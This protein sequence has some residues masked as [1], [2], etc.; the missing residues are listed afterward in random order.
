MCKEKEV[1]DLNKFIWVWEEFLCKKEKELSE[2]L[3]NVN[4]DKEVMC[5]EID[6]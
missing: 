1:V 4:C 2:V 6:L 3:V 5:Y